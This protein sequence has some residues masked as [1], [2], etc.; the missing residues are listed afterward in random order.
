MICMISY[1]ILVRL[2]RSG[3]PG[4][5]KAQKLRKLF[6]EFANAA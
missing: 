4:N 3:D 5:K 6:V 2:L 1:M